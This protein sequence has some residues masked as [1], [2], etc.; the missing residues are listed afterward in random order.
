[1][2]TRL[3]AGILLPHSDN[4]IMGNPKTSN[5]W[6]QINGWSYGFEIGARYAVY[7]SVYLELTT[8]M[9]YGELRG[10]PVYQGSA[11]QTIQMNEQTLSM[12]FLF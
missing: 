3:G 7:K 1:M 9:G 8:K 5:D 12:G 10:V 6:L 4:T 2:I 11:D